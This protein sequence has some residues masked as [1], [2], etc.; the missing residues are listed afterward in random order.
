MDALALE[1]VIVR[2]ENYACRCIRVT[3]VIGAVGDGDREGSMRHMELSNNVLDW[4]PYLWR[5]EWMYNYVYDACRC[6]VAGW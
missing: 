1:T 2:C 3:A 5:V 4:S 6:I